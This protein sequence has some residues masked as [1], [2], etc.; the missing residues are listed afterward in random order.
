MQPRR[1]GTRLT[2]GL[3]F[4][5]KVDSILSLHDTGNWWSRDYLVSA[6]LQKG[7]EGFYFE[8]PTGR[9]TVQA[10]T[11]SKGIKDCI[12][13][14]FLEQKQKS[15]ETKLTPEGDHIKKARSRRLWRRTLSTCL[16]IVTKDWAK[17]DGTTFDLTDLQ[18]LFA[19]L[20]DGRPP[21]FSY[22]Y[23]RIT[24]IKPSIFGS[25]RMPATRFR[26]LLELI[27]NNG[28]AEVA[29]IL[30]V[31]GLLARQLSHHCVSRM[32]LSIPEDELNAL[33]LYFEKEDASEDRLLS[34]YF[35]DNQKFHFLRAR[36]SLRADGFIR[37]RKI[38]ISCRGDEPEEE[39][40][41]RHNVCPHCA[42]Q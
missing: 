17:E 36:D 7:M 39:G 14:R 1:F 21:H 3:N 33:Y 24:Q 32:N 42:Q 38:R 28:C 11:V 40:S 18:T 25:S 26:Q 16:E 22:I 37:F 4:C 9:Q 2:M 10:S 8:G 20:D 35:V 5:D 29:R 15:W 30:P 23:Q 41:L 27:G 6:I 13:W 31:L 12:Y 19:S 34:Q